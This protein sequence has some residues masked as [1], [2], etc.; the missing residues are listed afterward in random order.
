MGIMLLMVSEIDRGS[1]PNVQQRRKLIP[2][3]QVAIGFAQASVVNPQ[4]CPFSGA[5]ILK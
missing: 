5:K 4:T 1:Q 3:P 2:L